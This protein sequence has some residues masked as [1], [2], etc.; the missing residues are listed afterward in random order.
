M[1]ERPV[2]LQIEHPLAA[3]N[4]PNPHL[5]RPR[6]R[7]FTQLSERGLPHWMAERRQL[8][9]VRSEG[10][11]RDGPP[12]GDF[13]RDG[14]TGHRRPE[15]ERVGRGGHQALTVWRDGDPEDRLPRHAQA[16]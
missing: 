14:L 10:Y 13:L 12:N 2:L 7:G 15:V 4:V 16:Q 9:A 3:I 1:N 11:A 5:L 8:P 6:R